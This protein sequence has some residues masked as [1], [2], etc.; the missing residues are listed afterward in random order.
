M[1][2][3]WIGILTSEVLHQHSHE[4]LR[5]QLKTY[6]LI[7]VQDCRISS[8]QLLEIAKTFGPLLK[9]AG[10]NELIQMV[11]SVDNTDRRKTFS[12]TTEMQWHSDRSFDAESPVWSLLYAQSADEFSGRT[13]WVNLKQAYERL[14]KPLQEECRGLKCCH[15][16]SHF[17]K[18]YQDEIYGFSNPRRQKIAFDR[19]R[20][21]KPLV[22]EWNGVPYLNINRG[23]TSEVVG[24]DHSFLEM[25]LAYV[26]D[27]SFAYY[28]TWRSGDLVISN[29]RVL[30]HRR[31]KSQTQNRVMYRVLTL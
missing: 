12:S 20:S 29:N 23:Y 10:V 30:V 19:C 2:P 21:I 25:L 13:I 6:D 24:R 31:E 16:L 18:C 3:A 8:D 14:P 28:H 11:P 9:K 22:E 27:E 7:V 5:D 15:E 26:E 4:E 1:A 17:S